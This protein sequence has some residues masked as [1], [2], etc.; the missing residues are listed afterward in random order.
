MKT[1][2][3]TSDLRY[4]RQSFSGCFDSGEVVGL[5][6][7]REGNQF[8]QFRQNLWSNYCWTSEVGA[9][10]HH[11]MTNSQH[12]RAAVFRMQPGSESSNPFRSVTSG[13]VPIGHAC[14]ACIFHRQARRGA[15]AFHEATCLQ[16]PAFA[17][18]SF[19]HTKFQAGRSRVEYECV[20]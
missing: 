4:S 11:T 17:R 10:M 3:E 14:T 19:K 6:Q 2:V 18:R 5:M 7:W 12:A 1:G 16:M 9:T 20:V 8:I 15:N 13:N